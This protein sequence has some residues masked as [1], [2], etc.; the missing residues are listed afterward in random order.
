VCPSKILATALENLETKLKTTQGASK[1]E[2][3]EEAKALDEC[4][5]RDCHATEMLL[6]YNG[7][8][9]E[10][11]G[12]VPYHTMLLSRIE[13]AD[14]GDV[15]A[16]TMLRESDKL[17]FTIPMDFINTNDDDIEI[18]SMASKEEM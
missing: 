12:P 10:H 9:F 18:K 3:I 13:P 16:R 6:E 17:I 11:R 7:I 5:P 15:L 8:F 14:D 2:E 4:D 1:E